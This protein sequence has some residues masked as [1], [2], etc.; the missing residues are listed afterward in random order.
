MNGLNR[1]II[2][3]LLLVSALLLVVVG[4]QAQGPRGVAFVLKVRGKLELKRH[5]EVRWGE[6]RRG[7]IL[8]SGDELRT[9]F[10]SLA[11]I[12]FTDNSAIIKMREN[13]YLTINAEREERTLSKRLY[14]EA[15][16]LWARVRPE[17]GPFRVETPTAVA[18]VKGTE[19]VM[20]VSPDGDTC[21]VYGIAGLIEL[22]NDYGV[23][24]VK[25]GFT[26]TSIAGSPP[27]VDTTVVAVS[28]E[29]FEIVKE[30][31]QELEIEFENPEGVK[32]KMKIKFR[33]RG[34]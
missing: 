30:M 14:M 29:M 21:V 25:A 15:G 26:G 27:S 12:K 22:L 19:W 2:R 6:A 18:S 1:R 9:G 32:R 7:T 4:A 34:E 33:E 3:P 23:V 16:D 31:E 8:N 11:A 13:T 24:T 28:T 17:S 20:F 5:G 10:N